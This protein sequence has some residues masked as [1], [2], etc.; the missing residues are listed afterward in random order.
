MVPAISE[1]SKER[2]IFTSLGSF[3][4]SIGWNGLTMIVVP[5]TTYFT[6]IATGKHEQGPSGVV[7]DFQ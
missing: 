2:G 3:T 1:D 6:F 7:L 4:G 5:V